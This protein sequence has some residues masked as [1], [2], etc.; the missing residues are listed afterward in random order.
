MAK[1]RQLYKPGHRSLYDA[2]SNGAL[3]QFLAWSAQSR[4]ATSLKNGLGQVS[5]C[6]LPRM[7]TKTT[8][9]NHWE[10]SQV[11]VQLVI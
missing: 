5:D 4:P 6:N 1:E 9:V 8:A 2:D 10:V 11:F 3:E 7:V